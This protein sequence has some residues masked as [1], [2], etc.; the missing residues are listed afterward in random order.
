MKKN[1]FVVD[2]GTFKN[3]IISFTLLFEQNKSTALIYF[4]LYVIFIVFSLLFTDAAAT[5]IFYSFLVM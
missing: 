5:G 1:H 3:T 2:L 4:R